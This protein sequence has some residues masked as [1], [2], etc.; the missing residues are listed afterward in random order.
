MSVSIQSRLTLALTCAV[1]TLSLAA[2][3]LLYRA[4][5]AEMTQNFD[6]GLLG[7][8]QAVVSL[9]SLEPGG[10]L[11]FEFNEAA[12][13]EYRA[14]RSSE[15]F[16]IRFVD[17]REYARSK[18]LAQADLGL[19]PVGSSDEN[20][21]YDLSLPDGRIARAIRIPFIPQSETP[22]PAAAAPM[23][24]VIARDR[25]DLDRSLG[26]LLGILIIA[27]SLL[28]LSTA[29]A[30]SM[31]VRH[32]LIPLRRVAEHAAAIDASRLEA[33]LREDGLPAEIAP[34]CSRLND[35]LSRLQ[36]AFDRERRF[37]SDVAHELRTPI[38]ELRSLAE[39]VLA[40]PEDHDAAHGAAADA[41]AIAIQMQTLVSTLL[42]LVRADHEKTRILL[43]PLAIATIV[44]DVVD[45]L[46]AAAAEVERSI[47]ESLVV[48][49]DPTLLNSVLLNLLNNAIEYSAGGQPVRC[50]AFNVDG[51]IQV[52]IENATSDLSEADLPKLFE[53]FWRKESSRTGTAHSG[54]G[55]SLVRAYCKL[56]SIEVAA[57]MHSGTT[58][59]ITLAWPRVAGVISTIPQP[60]LKIADQ[61]PYKAVQVPLG[62]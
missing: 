55:L 12:M 57:K 19:G 25:A 10:I 6:R 44:R 21:T 37:T 18:S 60:A 48:P 50:L 49:A 46:G 3:T 62:N 61:S 56:M 8:G 28:G 26:S 23:V 14:G 38:A 30:S 51:H 11:D 7:K 52:V 4:I 41:L 16:Q 27:S 35:L 40:W 29:V 5:G 20:T 36:A 13:P 33:R 59:Q 31:I 32:A 45:Q 47:D 34:I 24:A 9:V 17:G 15:Y 42:S 2:G 58:L 22:P 1:V 54:L 43:Q 53:P 39:V